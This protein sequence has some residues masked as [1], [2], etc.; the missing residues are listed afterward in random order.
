MLS[1]AL[2]RLGR[3]DLA[4]P[5]ARESYEVDAAAGRVPMAP[6][7]RSFA[8]VLVESGQREEALAVLQSAWDA[9]LARPMQRQ[10]RTD[11]AR[12][13]VAVLAGGSDRARYL[14]WA[15][16]LRSLADAGGGVP[17]SDLV[18]Q[19]ALRDARR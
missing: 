5:M 8:R 15:R 10:D 2:A 17:E 7:A 12:E 19:A 18:A 3:T 11:L 4:L 16:E 6:S 9:E 14:H 1:Y 13:F